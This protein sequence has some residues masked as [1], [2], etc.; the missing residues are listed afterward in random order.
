MNASKLFAAIAAVAFAG[1]AVAADV[2][3][4]NAAATSAA[5]AAQ[6]SVAAKSLNVP[7]VLVN[8]QAGRTRAEVRAEAVEAVKNHRATEAS[9]FDWLTK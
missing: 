8:K 4:A 1:A 5:A 7:A 6:V 2:P 9:Q 3:A